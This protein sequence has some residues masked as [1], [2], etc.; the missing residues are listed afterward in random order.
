MFFPLNMK[1]IYSASVIHDKRL[2]GY[3]S[4]YIIVHDSI[5]TNNVALCC[6]PVDA[7]GSVALF[8]NAI[9]YQM[10]TTVSRNTC[11]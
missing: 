2:Y 11:I 8:M 3:A 4:I 7:I 5:I 6:I 1:Y 9:A 10:N